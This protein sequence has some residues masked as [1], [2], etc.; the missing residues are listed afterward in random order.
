MIKTPTH[1]IPHGHTFGSSYTGAQLP[2][3]RE[4]Y[5]RDYD[6]HRNT[7]PGVTCP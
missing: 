3:T 2:E 7:D 4:S 1:K 5:A 6:E